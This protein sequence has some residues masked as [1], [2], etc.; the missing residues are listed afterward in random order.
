MEHQQALGA[1]LEQERA[2]EHQRGLLML[3]HRMEVSMD[4]HPVALIPLQQVDARPHKVPLALER[5][6]GVGHQHRRLETLTTL[7]RQVLVSMKTSR[8]RTVL[9]RLQRVLQPRDLHKMLRHPEVGKVVRRLQ[10][11]RG[12]QTLNHC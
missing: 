4:S 10:L 6:P 5:L 3:V 8:P 2:A 11:L 9:Q 1:A 7:P 12:E